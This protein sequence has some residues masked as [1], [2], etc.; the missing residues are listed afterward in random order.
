[1]LYLWLLE[2]LRLKLLL[3]LLELLLLWLESRGSWLLE[4]LLCR[5]SGRLGTSGAAIGVTAEKVVER[6]GDTA[7]KAALGKGRAE[8]ENTQ[9]YQ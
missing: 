3:R 4:L 7:E 5:S 1:M 9:A 6:A 8:S 2:L